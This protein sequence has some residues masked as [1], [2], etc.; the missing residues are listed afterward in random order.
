MAHVVAAGA[1]ALVYVNMKQ[2]R[3]GTDKYAAGIVNQLPDDFTLFV[4]RPAE[5]YTTLHMTN[6]WEGGDRIRAWQRFW[7]VPWQ[8]RQQLVRDKLL[9]SRYYVAENSDRRDKRFVAGPE[10]KF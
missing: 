5:V 1:A 6:E 3:K 9:N 4:P 8:I 2:K 10:Y 7:G